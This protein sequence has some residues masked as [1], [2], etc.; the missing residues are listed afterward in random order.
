MPLTRAALSAL[1]LFALQSP[2]SADAAW[3]QIPLPRNAAAF[4]VGE[5]MLINGQPLQM[6]GFT[7]NESRDQLADWFRRSLGQPLVENRIG[8]KLILGKPSGDYY[9]T[10]QL[11]S[12]GNRTRGLAAITHLKAAAEQYEETRAGTDYWLQRL[13]SGSR[14]LSHMSSEDRGKRSRHLVVVNEH[15]EQANCDNLTAL[16]KEQGLILERLSRPADAPNRLSAP[17]PGDARA[18]FFKGEGKEGMAT[19][20]RNRQ[21]Q[22]IVVINTVS[23]TGASRP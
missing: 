7:A 3:P 4:S 21:G 11:E 16:L 2:A 20:A 22:T 10:V 18:L 13:P 17:S 8:N 23:S 15:S 6:K 19:V 14:L 1:C 12:S 5:R 9:L